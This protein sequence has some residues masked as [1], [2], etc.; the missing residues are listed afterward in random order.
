[1][2][3]Q[4]EALTLALEALEKSTRYFNIVRLG[5]S[6]LKDTEIRCASHAA[7]T[8]IKEALAQ[9]EQKWVYGTPLLDAMSKDYVAPQRPW[10]GLTDSERAECWSSSAKQSAINIEAKLKEKNT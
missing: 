4:T 1:M 5:E 8:A 9:P 10:V 6:R 3:K 2:T 7:I